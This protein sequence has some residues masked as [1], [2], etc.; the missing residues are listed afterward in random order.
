MLNRRLQRYGGMHG[1]KV[2]VVGFLSTQKVSNPSVFELKDGVAS[3]LLWRQTVQPVV[4][5]IMCVF[6]DEDA[7]LVAAGAISTYVLSS[8]YFLDP[9]PSYFRICKR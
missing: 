6:T 9:P 2:H 8:K 7:Q 3:M 5:C 1:S 4:A